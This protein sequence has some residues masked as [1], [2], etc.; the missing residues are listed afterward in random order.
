MYISN[1]DVMYNR[2]WFNGNWLIALLI[3]WLAVLMPTQS[4]G[5]SQTSKYQIGDLAPNFVGQDQFGNKIE[6]NETL[7]K[8]PVV[9]MFYR[10]YWCPYCNK[11]LAQL[12]DSLSFITDKGGV[13]IAVTPEQPEG[14]KK[15]IEKTGA[16]FLI[17]HDKDL[18]IMKEYGISFE[19]EETL[20]KRYKKK[21][22]MVEEN[23]GANGPNLPV[24]A[25][26]IINTDGRILYAFYDPDYKNRATVRKILEN[27]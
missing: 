26:Y 9:L 13:V 14:I 12:E 21:G 8:S 15:T 27:L 11:Q 3:I 25:T 19:M 5:Q 4:L 18:K 17:I 24:P 23:N 1:V 22:L 10:G 16:S 2:V 20:L 6:L 7:K